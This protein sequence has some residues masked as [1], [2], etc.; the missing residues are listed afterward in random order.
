M[1]I[2]RRLA[3]P[4][5]AG[6]GAA[7]LAG[8]LLP[9]ALAPFDIWPLAVLCPLALLALL[10][11]LR[12]G[13]AALRA[14]SFGVGMFGTGASWVYVSIHQ[15]GSA[16]VPLAGVLTLRLY[17]KGNMTIGTDADRTDQTAGNHFV[18]A[19]SVYV[20]AGDVVQVN[21]AHFHVF[22][23]SSIKLVCGGSAI[24]IESGSIQITSG[25]PVSVNGGVVKLNCD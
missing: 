8:A 3:G 11:H 20:D 19:G 9:A 18:K 23:K 7:L 2:L 17:S 4:G 14:W 10:R 12:P 24:V 6:H 1:N 16:P 21:A 22:A 13:A 5:I 25:G 15:Y